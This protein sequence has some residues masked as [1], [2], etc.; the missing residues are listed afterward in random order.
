MLQ[1][2]TYI[3]VQFWALLGAFSMHGNA[4]NRWVNGYVLLRTKSVFQS[5]VLGRPEYNAN[6]FW[7]DTC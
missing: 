7:L 5:H 2:T 1:H 3:V 6:V 4:A